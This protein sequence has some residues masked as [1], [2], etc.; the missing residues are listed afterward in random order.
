MSNEPLR[1][2]AL[3]QLIFPTVHVQPSKHCC[4]VTE[5]ILKGTTVDQDV[6]EEDDDKH[7]EAKKQ[8]GIYCPLEGA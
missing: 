5:M 1:E 8:G 3:G 2:L 7:A 4:K 6:I